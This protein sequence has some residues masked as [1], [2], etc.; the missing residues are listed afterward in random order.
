M[1]NPLL[2]F[3]SKMLNFRKS[4]FAK[5]FLALLLLNL[6]LVFNI[7]ASHGR[8]NNIS[9][10]QSGNTVTYKVTQAF[11]S[12]YF[13]GARSIGEVINTGDFYFGD[14]NISPLDISVIS[15]NNSEDF[16]IGQYSISHTYTSAGNFTAGFGSCCRLSSL[17]NAGDADYQNY[18]TVNVG[19][20]NASPV[21]QVPVI[22]NLLQGNASASFQI[23]ALD[24]EGAALSYSLA[25]AADMGLGYSIPAG[26]SI[27]S[28]GLL[29]LNTTGF[30]AGNILAAGV[31]ITDAAGASI[32]VDFIIEISNS[33]ASTYVLF[34]VPPTPNNAQ[35]YDVN[36]G[37]SV[38]FNV[39]A[40][41][42]LN[43]I[44]V[45]SNI[46]AAF[47]ANILAESGVSLYATGL[48]NGSVFNGGS[49]TNP[50]A[51]AFSWTPTTTDIGS[52]IV[53]F[54][55]TDDN[56][57]QA[58]TTVRI[59]VLGNIVPPPP[60]PT[61]I[62]LNAPS[63]LVI[64]QFS[65]NALKLK[66]DDVVGSYEESFEIYRSANGAAG[67]FELIATPAADVVE[68][69][70][71][72]IYPNFTYFYYVRARFGTGF[73]A[74]TNVASGMTACSPTAPQV[75][76][77]GNVRV[78]S[79][80]CSQLKVM[81]DDVVGR[82][83]ESYEVMRAKDRIDGLYVA[84][85]QPKE[86][87]LQWIDEK[88]NSNTKYYYIVRA[89]FNDGYSAYT[90]PVGN[91]TSGI[92]LKISSNCA[93]RVVL[94]WDNCTKHRER[95]VVKTST[96]N[97]N[98][99][100]VANVHEKLNH[101][102][103]KNLMPNT[104]YYFAVQPVYSNGFSNLSNIVSVMLPKFPSP[105]ELNAVV[106]DNKVNLTWKDNS[107][108][109]DFEENF[110]VYRK[111]ADGKFTEIG[112]AEFDKPYFTDANVVAEK[113]YCYI[114]KP[115]YYGGYEDPSNEACVTVPKLNVIIPKVVAITQNT[116]D[117]K[118]VTTTLITQEATVAPVTINEIKI[119]AL[120]LNVN[121]AINAPQVELPKAINFKSVEERLTKIKGYPN[122]AINI[123]K[124]AVNNSIEGN[125]KVTLLDSYGKSHLQNTIVNMDQNKE[126]LLDITSL[127]AGMYYLQL[128]GE[129]KNE[130]ITLKLLKIE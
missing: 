89:R 125:V 94:D 25:T 121:L 21:S 73:S 115:R 48:P 76:K 13:G 77:L 120:D 30:S 19:S 50:V 70:D 43:Q 101:Y 107:S 79:E 69:Y 93:T 11:R 122:P 112:I 38:N 81:W 46:S 127:K 106:V 117:A 124:F 83:E 64:S 74:T 40:S 56:S 63:N 71:N 91:T 130:A 36:V 109:C 8:Y 97:V 75:G 103:V 29:Q 17:I 68:Y 49:G 111:G 61:P 37:Q 1:K 47:I 105:S 24:P 4:L 44:Q 102:E 5:T 58:I 95:W 114:V 66:W 22:V 60:P 113:E 9:Y 99:Y 39:S 18:V 118:A 129:M 96:D 52:Y 23:Q 110:K 53:S 62:V 116:T 85:D 126:Y 80:G 12:T 123:F 45:S 84:V 128:K 57:Q 27:S 72:L 34:D 92:G 104:K 55:A 7:E 15:I 51:S 33:L 54:V 82:Y 108:L 14:G 31:L 28:T 16:F 88:L 90:A 78:I 119:G 87:V 10:T 32:L 20:G 65:C 100:E 98:F 42:F 26:L 59:N 86:N 35:V 6:L 2:S 41:S 3:E 67:P